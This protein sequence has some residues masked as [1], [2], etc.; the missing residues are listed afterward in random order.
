MNITFSL[1]NLTL[2]F[3]YEDYGKK[4]VSLD[5][6]DKYANTASKRWPLVLTSTL[7]NDFEYFSIASIPEVTIQGSDIQFNV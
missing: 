6:I 4:F 1:N 2:S 7:D 5:L 3:E